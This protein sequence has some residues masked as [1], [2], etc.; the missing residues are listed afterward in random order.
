MIVPHVADELRLCARALPVVNGAD[1][2]RRI[3]GV[4]PHI[5]VLA[6]TMFD[7]DKSVFQI[8]RAGA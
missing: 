2:T 5:G 6:L 4:S 1:A 3:L 8:M 7:E